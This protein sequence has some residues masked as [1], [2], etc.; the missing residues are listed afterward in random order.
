[1]LWHGKPRDDS[2]SRDARNNREARNIRKTSNIRDA[3]DIIVESNSRDAKK[4]MDARIIMDV[5]NSRMKALVGRQKHQD[6]SKVL[7][8]PKYASNS[9][10]RER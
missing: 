7:A 2:S 1:M 5:I 8:A 6:D 9:K 3:S 10:S 4:S